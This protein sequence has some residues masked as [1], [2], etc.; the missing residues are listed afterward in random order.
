LPSPRLFQNPSLSGK[1]G[2]KVQP[3][4]KLTSTFFIFFS[5]NSHHAD[6]EHEIFSRFTDFEGFFAFL[7]PVLGEKPYFKN[8]I[9]GGCEGFL[10]VNAMLFDVF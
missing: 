8:L 7:K 1:A 5:K 4:C 3:F 2:A 6:Y 10:G 9:L